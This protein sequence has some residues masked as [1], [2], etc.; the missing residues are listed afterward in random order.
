MGKAGECN[1]PGNQATIEFSRVM[2]LG[3]RHGVYWSGGWPGGHGQPCMEKCW[4]HGGW[5]VLLGAGD[6]LGPNIRNTLSPSHCLDQAPIREVSLEALFCPSPGWGSCYPG[7]GE[8]W[9]TMRPAAP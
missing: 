4:W 6:T 3:I 5:K 1:G 8:K 7:L 9:R 2:G